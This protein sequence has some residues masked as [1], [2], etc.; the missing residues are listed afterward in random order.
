MPDSPG[1][2]GSPLG[3]GTPMAPGFPSRPT[4]PFLPC[5]EIGLLHSKVH[6]AAIQTPLFVLG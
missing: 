4:E 5:A 3:P 6:K 2:P 1:G